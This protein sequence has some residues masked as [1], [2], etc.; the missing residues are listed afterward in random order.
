[1]PQL[2]VYTR[3]SINFV[4]FWLLF[5]MC[6]FW[7]NSLW[8]L[9][10]IRR[11]LV[12]RNDTQSLNWRL[13]IIVI[14]WWGHVFLIAHHGRIFCLIEDHRRVLFFLLLKVFFGNVVLFWIFFNVCFVSKSKNWGLHHL[15]S[16]DI[17]Q[18]SKILFRVT[19]ISQYHL[20]IRHLLFD[21][22]VF[23]LWNCHN[24]W[25]HFRFLLVPYFFWYLGFFSYGFDISNQTNFL[26]N[27]FN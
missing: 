10:F 3:K 15:R 1:M 9:I 23:I 22:V 26:R 6:L 24:C 4:N 7:I 18:I 2:C 19:I 20:V 16:I 25:F 5:L 8:I 12:I 17:N 14:C 27:W 21:L 11:L 13:S